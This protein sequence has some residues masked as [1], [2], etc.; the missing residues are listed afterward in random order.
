[1][2]DYQKVKEEERIEFLEKEIQRLKKKE[3]ISEKIKLQNQEEIKKL[4]N[5]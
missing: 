2:K 3:F 1:M 5:F 4:G